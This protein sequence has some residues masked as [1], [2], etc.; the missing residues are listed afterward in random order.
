[1][2]SKWVYR[3]SDGGEHWSL[4]ASVNFGDPNSATGEISPTGDFGPLNVLAADPNRAWL[5]E[6]RGGVLVS[7]DGGLDWQ[8]AF[9]DPEADAFGPPY[10]SFL[11]ATHGWAETGDGLWRTTDGTTWTEIGSPNGTADSIDVVGAAR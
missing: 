11:D 3:S 9:P 4:M 5:A 2:S 10:V 8:Y 1:M 6:D 7:N